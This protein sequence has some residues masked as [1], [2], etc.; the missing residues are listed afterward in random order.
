LKIDLIN[1]IFQKF[2]N[3]GESYLMIKSS[4][5]VALAILIIFVFQS[6]QSKK[7]DDSN[8]TNDNSK[9]NAELVKQDD[10]GQKVDLRYV[11]KSS[12]KFKYSLTEE[13]FTVENS[14]DTKFKDEISEQKVNYYYAEDVAEISGT[15]VITYRVKFD[16]INISTKLSDQP[17]PQI[18]NSNVKDSIYNKPVYLQY[19]A[20]IGQDF[21]M[22]VSAQGEIYDVYELEK[23]HDFIF[24]AFGDTLSPKDKENIKN[25]MGPE[26][27]KN[28]LQN[29]FQKFPLSE[30]YKDSSWVFNVE[31]NLLVF[32]VKNVLSYKLADV[33][34]ENG[35][36]ICSIESTL[37]IDFIQT[38]QKDNQLTL[39]I[40]DS[41]AGGSG[42]VSFDAS[43]GCI[44]S[45]KTNMNI[46]IEIR[47]SAKGQSAISKQNLTKAYTI[48]L[49]Q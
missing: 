3:Q 5:N 11:P 9:N 12:E 40:I 7:Q 16:S 23:I 20:L 24:K 1:G 4:I 14:P 47:L 37:G 28:I 32:P 17:Q 34:K 43:K 18:Y 26:A 49:L 48:A 25:L 2:I 46:N 15:G 45:K 42:K 36:Y 29:Q 13:T 41:K 21:K 31:S 39:K 6:C 44:V 35:D 30:V 10:K 33:K 19:N 22:R 38:E 8:K 27:I